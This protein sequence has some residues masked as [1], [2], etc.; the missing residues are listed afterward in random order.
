M[1]LSAEEVKEPENGGCTVST[2]REAANTQSHVV[3]GA[4]PRSGGAP[5]IG[6]STCWVAHSGYGHGDRDLVNVARRVNTSRLVKT[7]RRVKTARLVNT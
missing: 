6:N 2:P 4:T 7:A 3:E 5:G 1:P